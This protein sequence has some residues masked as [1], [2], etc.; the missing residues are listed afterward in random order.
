MDEATFV[1]SVR[2]ALAHLYDTVYL[3][4]HPLAR[5]LNLANGQ[6]LHRALL[7]AIRSQQ[8]PPGSPA[9]TPAWRLYRIL[10][11]RY[12]EDR[13]VAEIARELAISARQLQRDHQRALEAVAATL[14]ARLP[15]A[16]QAA[17]PEG[18]PALDGELSQYVAASAPGPTDV[19]ETLQ[20]VLALLAARQQGPQAMAEISAPASLPLARVDRVI[21]RQVLIHLLTY[22]LDHP[23]AAD[24]RI[25]ATPR[26]TWVTVTL[27]TTIGVAGDSKG[28]EGRL[29]TARQL[30]SAQGCRLDGPRKEAQVVTLTLWLPAYGPTTIL[31]IDDNPDVIR[32]FQRYLGAA[33][34]RVVGVDNAREAVRLARELRPHAITLDLMMPTQD[35]WEILQTLKAHAET[36]DIPIVVC[37]VLRE[38]ELALALGAAAFLAKPI[39]QRQLV[40]A[41]QEVLRVRQM[42]DRLSPTDSE[43]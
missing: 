26:E 12:L 15:T 35:G 2:E 5:W 31:V 3:Q 10:V 27:C 18:I 28:D 40:S 39:N 30:L 9:T 17:E 38:R 8:P 7:E 33:H 13:P 42:P 22:L 14:R 43:S 41:L 25:V 11:L 6:A 1:A 21:L 34:A 4:R 36:R 20:G 16:A 37:S 19:V 32:L 29:A 23:S 24:L